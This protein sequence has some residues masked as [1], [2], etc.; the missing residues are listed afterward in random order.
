MRTKQS[1][2]EE[3]IQ[4]GKEQ[5]QRK[6]VLSLLI[7]FPDFTDLKIAIL[8]KAEIALVTKIRLELEAKVNQQL[9][10]GWQFIREEAQLEE[11]LRMDR[12]FV[13]SLLTKAPEL[14]DEKIAKIVKVKKAFVTNL[15]RKLSNETNAV[16]S[17]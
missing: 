15:R 16:A 5:L 2:L 11:N 4:I 13:I 9:P 3:G 17:A 1:I 10:R 12:Q 7:E 6:I 8:T 14:T